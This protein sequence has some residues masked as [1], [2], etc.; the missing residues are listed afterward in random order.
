MKK[1]FFTPFLVVFQLAFGQTDNVELTK[2]IEVY[3]ENYAESLKESNLGKL[4][5]LLK[6]A[7]TG[8]IILKGDIKT[9]GVVEI[10]VIPMHEKG[11]TKTI[12]EFLY[13]LNNELYNPL[14]FEWIP[15]MQPQM[16]KLGNTDYFICIPSQKQL[17]R[18]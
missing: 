3:G 15:G 2:I 10:E 1:Y 12:E 17:N 11:K 16:Y 9:K 5:F 6:Y 13:I 7:T 18:I 4:D 14:V 8:F